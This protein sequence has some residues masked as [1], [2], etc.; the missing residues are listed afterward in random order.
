MLA[1][2][3]SVKPLAAELSRARRGYQV[4]VRNTTGATLR[5]VTIIEEGAALV[6]TS[7]FVAIGDLKSGESKT[8]DLKRGASRRFLNRYS[9]DAKTWFRALD[10]PQAWTQWPKLSPAVRSSPSSALRYLVVSRL[11]PLVQVSG[12]SVDSVSYSLR[13]DPVVVKGGMQRGFLGLTVE[14]GSSYTFANGESQREVRIGTVNPNG[15]AKRAGLTPGL[16]INTFN[17]KDIHSIK[18]FRELVSRHL[19]GE[20]V[21]L[22]CWDS[23]SGAQRS[24]TVK[25]VTKDRIEGR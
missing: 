9:K 8:V 24:V 12:Q 15:P 6:W 19:P 7:P 20:K 13:I 1:T 5:R 11:D 3:P 22:D 16:V 21:R 10:I 23:S 18:Q 4:T 17:G 14:P 2:V 25:L